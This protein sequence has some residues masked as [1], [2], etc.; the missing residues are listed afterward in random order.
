MTIRFARFPFVRRY[1]RPVWIAAAVVALAG[2]IGLRVFTLAVPPRHEATEV[3]IPAQDDWIDY[4]LIFEAGAPG[5]WDYYLWGGF[6]AAAI[7]FEG[8]YYLYYQGASGYQ[9]EPDETV[10]GRTIGVATSA[11]GISFAKLPD[12][13]VVTWSPFDHG[14]EGAVSA[15]VTLDAEQRIALYYGAN[16]MES[17]T[18]VNADARLAVSSDG[19]HFVD[20]G[21]VID[22]TDGS[23]W[24]SGDEIFPVLALHDEG[25]WYVYY[26]PNGTWQSGLVGVAWG[27]APDQLTETRG[28]LSGAQRVS[29]WGP[30]GYGRIAPRTYALFFSNIRQRHIEVRTVSLDT[31][32]QVSAPVHRYTFPDVADATVLLDQEN[33][34][35]FMYYRLTDNRGYGVMQAPAINPAGRPNREVNQ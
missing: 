4:G 14:E 30:A 17:E 32:D 35:W 6:A 9:I 8:T 12:N 5:D 16:I 11:D 27:P 2:L 28:V 13:P 31:P 22:H 21:S 23:V 33:D 15:G 7:K 20:T 24:G 34:T 18:T 19:S 10:T 29:A 1:V 3:T 25:R 26:I